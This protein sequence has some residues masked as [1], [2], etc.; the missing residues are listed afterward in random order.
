MVKIRGVFRRKFTCKMSGNP[1]RHF[2]ISGSAVSDTVFGVTDVLDYFLIIV[3][4][5][6]FFENSFLGEVEGRSV[7][8]ALIEFGEMRDNPSA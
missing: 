3:E 6:C 5:N 1:R 2:E 8:I 7:S 4:G